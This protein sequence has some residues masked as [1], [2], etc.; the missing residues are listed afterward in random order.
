MQKRIEKTMQIQ[1]R[2]GCVLGGCSD[3]IPM[4][5]VAQAPPPITLFFKKQ[6]KHTNAHAPGAQNAHTLHARQARWRIWGPSV[7]IL[8]QARAS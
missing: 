4:A 1:M 8:A 5:G 3:G 6:T 2:F 7:A